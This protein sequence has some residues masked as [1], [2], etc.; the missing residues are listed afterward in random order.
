M[1]VTVLAFNSFCN[2]PLDSLISNSEVLR[3]DVAYNHNVALQLA[4]VEA[5][6]FSLS[7]F[8]FYYIFYLYITFIIIITVVLVSGCS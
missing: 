1:L 8:F 4:W 3:I 6:V 7:F 5:S 2:G